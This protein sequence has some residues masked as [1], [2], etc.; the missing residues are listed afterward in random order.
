ME[1]AHRIVAVEL[2][3]VE[4]GEPH[5][6]A[7]HK[8]VEGSLFIVSS[9]STSAL[10]SELTTLCRRGTV[11][12]LICHSL[13]SCVGMELSI[14]ESAKLFSEGRVVNQEARGVAK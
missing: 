7:G 14:C 10:A 9:L 11:G 13:E 5:M 6:V 12:R 2:H 8:V 1:E 4:E 3:I